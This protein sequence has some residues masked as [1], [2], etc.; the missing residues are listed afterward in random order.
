MTW[1]DEQR[2]AVVNNLMDLAA[3]IDQQRVVYVLTIDAEGTLS[4]MRKVRKD[5]SNFEL[6]G[7][8]RVMEEDIRGEL[9]QGWTV[10]DQPFRSE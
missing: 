3:N 7:A 2:E 9:Q 5:G 6:V 4:V 8:L 1:T 10:K